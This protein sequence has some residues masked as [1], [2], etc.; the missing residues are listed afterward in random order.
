MEVL[1]NRTEPSM[2]KKLPPP[3]C[4]DWKPPGLPPGSFTPDCREWARTA[5]I[6]GR[7]LVQPRPR[8]GVVDGLGPRNDTDPVGR[9]EVVVPLSD[10]HRV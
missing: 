4:C 8:C 6:G 3:G 5:I 10:A 2:K 7:Q 1:R 9:D